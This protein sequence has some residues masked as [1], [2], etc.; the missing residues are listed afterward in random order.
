MNAAK[1]VFSV[2][3]GVLVLATPAV[4]IAADSTP[5]HAMWVWKSPTVLA[6]TNAA[7]NLSRLLPVEWH[8]RSIRFSLNWQHG[9]RPGKAV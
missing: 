5:V 2:V 4:A 8:R 3:A 7:E 6:Q 1:T 9:C